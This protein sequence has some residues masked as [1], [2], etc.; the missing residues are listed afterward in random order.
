MSLLAKGA[1]KLLTVFV[2]IIKVQNSSCTMPIVG[3]RG[4][5]SLAQDVV[6][7]GGNAM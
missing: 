5:R 7:G 1:V 3:D 4:P 6:C 2:L